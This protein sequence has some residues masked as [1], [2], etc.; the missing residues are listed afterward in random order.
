[1]LAGTEAG[2]WPA[3]TE[4]GPQRASAVRVRRG[5]SRVRRRDWQAALIIEVVAA[6]RGVTP[7]HLLG[8]HKSMRVVVT[9]QL[10]MYLVHT[11][12]GRTYLETAR[13]FDRDRTTVSHACAR[14]EDRRE[15]HSAFEREVL[16]FERQI[17][18]ALDREI[19]HGLQ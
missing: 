3:G 8:R 18:E 2:V 9:R 17:L 19:N 7:R 6:A 14:I 1:M 5:Y 12:L 4:G 13:L 16:R 10:A 11:L 15:D